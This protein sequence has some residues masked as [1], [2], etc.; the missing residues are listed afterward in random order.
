[1]LDST[2]EF[3]KAASWVFGVA[4]A[5]RLVALWAGVD[6]TLVMDEIAYAARAEAL[7]D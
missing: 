4:L 2:A 3:R 6:A 1:M 7:L 5:V